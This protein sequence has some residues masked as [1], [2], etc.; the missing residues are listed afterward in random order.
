MVNDIEDNFYF[1]S[2]IKIEIIIADDLA[3]KFVSVIIEAA[4]TRGVW[5]SKAF[6]PTINE[7]VKIRT[8]NVGKSEINFSNN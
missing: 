8:T 2:N 6:I 7:E 5:L 4:K 3:E 1:V